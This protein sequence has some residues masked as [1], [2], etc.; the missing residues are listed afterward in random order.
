MNNKQIILKN[1]PQG[2]PD[3]HT[4][5]LEVQSILIVKFEQII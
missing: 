4:W 3:E 5:K 2:T 1:R